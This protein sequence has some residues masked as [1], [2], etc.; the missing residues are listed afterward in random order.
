MPKL[1][2]LSATD[3]AEVRAGSNGCSFMCGPRHRYHYRGEPEHLLYEDP[4]SLTDK[5]S[6]LHCVSPAI[7]S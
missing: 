2:D 3:V 5:E 1:F 7:N 6:L 4:I